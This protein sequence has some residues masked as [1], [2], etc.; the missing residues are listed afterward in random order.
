MVANQTQSGSRE[1]EGR[2]SQCPE[3][4]DLCSLSGPIF[5]DSDWPEGKLI[6]EYACF[7]KTVL[8]AILAMYDGINAG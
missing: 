5:H 3:V 1:A 4:E 6:K 7:L 8:S 2:D